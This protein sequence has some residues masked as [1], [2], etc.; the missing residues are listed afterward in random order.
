MEYTFTHQGREYSPTFKK[1]IR[2]YINFYNFFIKIVFF[3]RFLK[4]PVILESLSKELSEIKVKSL[5]DTDISDH[6]ETLFVESLAVKPRLIVELGVRTGQSTFV[7]ERVAKLSDAYLVS[8]DIEPQKS[9]SSWN[10]WSFVHEDDLVFADRFADWCRGKRIEPKI[11]VL[12]IDTSHEYNQTK[13]EISKWFP[14]L[15]EKAVVFFHDANVRLFYKRRNGTIGKAY[16]DDRDVMR[17]IE[18]YLGTHFNE[19]KD[20]IKIEGFWLIKHKAIC[21]GMTIL[22]RTSIVK[23]KMALENARIVIPREAVKYILFQRTQH[24]FFRRNEFVR[25]AVK[26]FPKRI[27]YGFESLFSN[28]DNM[29]SLESF[30]TKKRVTELFNEEMNAEYQKMMPFLPD[31]VG[32]I[33]DIGCGVAG[34]DVLLYK[35]YMSQNPKI[36]LIDK[37]EMPSKVYYSYRERGCYYNSLDTSRSI[38]EMNGVPSQNIFLQEAENNQIKFDEKFNLVISLISWGFHYPLSTYLAQVY[39]K[40][41]SGGT[42]IIDV[43]KILTSDPIVELRDKFGKVNIIYESD[44]HARV[45]ALK[46]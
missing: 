25:K 17:A 26:L 4:S 22:K 35:H 1:N 3:W 29:V 7:F 39:E 6:L 40:M 2:R 38:L 9:S 13:R 14:F 42:L 30:F 43:R 44:K 12:F 31:R 41:A 5:I 33:L 8:V 46:Q 27:A 34:I 11:D 32:S 16:N 21:N 45:V 36:Y 28:F 19:K 10:K 37:T 23:S 18:E 15:S 24:L 20:F